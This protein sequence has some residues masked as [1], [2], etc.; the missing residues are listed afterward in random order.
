MAA[1]GGPPARR[2]RHGIEVKQG[3]PFR[4]WR[5]KGIAAICFLRPDYRRRRQRPRVHVKAKK[6]KNDMCCPMSKGGE[7]KLH[8]H[9]PIRVAQT[10]RGPGIE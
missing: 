3:V 8:L 4:R 10:V 5:A 1:G 9:F 6:M 2:P 7:S